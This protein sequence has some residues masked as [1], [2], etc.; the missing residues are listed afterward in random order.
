MNQD[1]I[2]CCSSSML[3]FFY[4]SPNAALL[5]A[6]CCMQCC[7]TALVAQAR[8]VAALVRSRPADAPPLCDYAVGSRAGRRAGLGWHRRLLILV[9]YWTLALSGCF[10]RLRGGGL[11]GTAPVF[12]RSAKLSAPCSALR[13]ALCGKRATRISQPV[14]G[15]EHAARTHDA[16]NSALLAARGAA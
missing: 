12:E 3:L 2:V 1:A 4:S 9:S 16:A 7:R 13:A 15:I 14:R 10:P 11:R 6:Q 8:A 5:C